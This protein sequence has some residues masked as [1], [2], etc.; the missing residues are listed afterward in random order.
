MRI[1]QTTDL[2]EASNPVNTQVAH[3]RTSEKYAHVSSER[4]IQLFENKNFTL[5]GVSKS[6]SKK[7]DGYQKHMMIFTR[8]DLRI[9]DENH[10]RFLVRNDHSGMGSV[11][12]D[13]GIFRTIC[14][15]GM[16]IGDKNFSHRIRHSGNAEQKVHQSF[17]YFMDNLIKIKTF[18]GDLKSN[19]T[20]REQREALAHM[21]CQYRL[22]GN[23]K[24]VSFDANSALE[25]R[26]EEDTAND[27]YT[28]FNRLQESLLRGGISFDAWGKVRGEDREAILKKRTRAITSL[29]MSM[30]ANKA[31]YNMVE[32]ML[33]GKKDSPEKE[34]EL[35]LAA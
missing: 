20:T 23:K 6:R 27:F 18:I 9:D 16:E 22:S 29:D 12:I 13:L 5:E 34:S 17:E 1:L 7:Y 19:P 30:K 35:L 24:L 8:D 33:I 15:N 31:V 25:H 11:G 14:A 4:I 10:L 28:V 26:R 21:V 3:Q 32:E 2:N